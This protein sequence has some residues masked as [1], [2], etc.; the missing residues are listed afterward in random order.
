[1]HSCNDMIFVYIIVQYYCVV[2]ADINCQFTDHYTDNCSKLQEVTTK[3]YCCMRY[4][5]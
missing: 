1:M 4:L 5:Q 3:C 2:E